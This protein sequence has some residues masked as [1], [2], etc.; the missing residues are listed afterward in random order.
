MKD[1]GRGRE[2]P[3]ECRAVLK[4][5]ELATINNCDTNGDTKEKGKG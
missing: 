4:K 3:K 1:E 5:I 2:I